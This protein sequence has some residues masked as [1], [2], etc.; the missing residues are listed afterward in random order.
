MAVP[1]PGG[2]HPAVR[3]RRLR[4]L[5]MLT[6]TSLLALAVA[7]GVSIAIA[8]PSFTILVGILATGAALVFLFTNKRLELSIGMIAIYVGMLEGPIKLGTGA[9]KS[10]TA[11]RD[12]L[13]G[14]V[15]LGALMRLSRSRQRVRVPPLA[16]WVFAFIG[17]V[18]VEAFN[19]KT[20]GAAKALAGFRQN[21][22]WVPFFFFG[23]ALMRSRRNFRRLFMVLGAIALANGIVGAY[24]TRL[25]P[26]QLGSWGPGYHE[27]VFGG[28]NGKGLSGR[29]FVL[30]GEVHVRPPGLGTDAGFGGGVGAVAL[31]A[32]LA[33]LVAG[34][35]RRQW[36]VLLFTFGALTAVLT[37][38]GRLQAVGAV[39]SLVFFAALAFTLG[40]RISR[41]LAILL[42]TIVLIVP[43]GAVLVSTLG[44]NQFARF[45]TVTSGKDT[46]ASDLKQI[47]RLVG[48]DPFGSGLGRTG[49]VSGFGGKVENEG[50]EHEGLASDTAYNVFV[51][52]LGLPGLLLF[53][54]LTLR[55]LTLLLTRVRRIA[56]VEIRIYLTA[57]AATLIAFTIMGFSGTTMTSGAYGPFFWGAAGIVAYW[58][59]GPG[60]KRYRSREPAVHPAPA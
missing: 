51:D 5:G 41:S 1:A 15:A 32:C 17:L 40:G 12:V 16:A 7:L 31:P 54:G 59:A 13:I 28:E 44:S 50:L 20:A 58:L 37:G 38:L 57:I 27:I 29:T 4:E 39:L 42:G 52:E 10:A 8:K 49:S 19:P 3:A 11:L 34:G 47:P 36:P 55:L 45:L 2:A 46:K 30:E 60:L 22:E 56:D 9:G 18:L 53:A 23:Y 48:R 35:L 33:L 24:Q 6:L 26:E 14:I 25:N 43:A 21:L